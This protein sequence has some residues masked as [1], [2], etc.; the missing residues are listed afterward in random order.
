MIDRWRPALRAACTGPLLCLLAACATSHGGGSGSVPALPAAAPAPVTLEHPP[1]LIVEA[2]VT[3]RQG[4]PAH[5]LKVTDFEVTVDG[6]RRAGLA[7]GRLYRGPGADFSASRGPGGPGEVQPLSESSRIVVMVV[8][9]AS[10]SPGDERAARAAVETLVGMLGL[11]DRLAVVTLPPP[12]DAMTIDFERAAGAKLLANLRPLWG[13]APLP[14]EADVLQA[15][16]PA[17]QPSDSSRPPD[18]EAPPTG[19]GEVRTEASAPG[20]RQRVQAPGAEEIPPDVLKAHAAS[21]LGSLMGIAH[22][23]ESAPGAKTVVLF[24]AGLVA[25]DFARELGALVDEAARAHTRIVSVQVPT[26]S[27]LRGAGAADLGALANATGG[28]L[29]ALGGKPQQALE[30]LAGELSFSYL[31]MLSPMAGDTDPTPRRVAIALKQPGGRTVQ[32]P[33]V[34]LPGRFPPEVLASALSPRAEV[35]AARAAASPPP[36]LAAGTETPG[37]ASAP[38]PGFALFR[39]DP[40]VDLVLARVSQYVWGYIRELSSVVSEETYAQRVGR[41]P[42]SLPGQAGPDAQKRTLAS[43]YLLVMVPGLNG[44]IPFRDVFEVD[45]KPVRDR[46]DRLVKLFVDAP[47]PAVA[48]ERAMQVLRE[49][50]RY[51]IGPVQRT[52][53]VPT[54]PIS[55]LEPASTHR[56]AFRKADETKIDGRTAWVLEFTELV[57]PTF[58]RTNAGADLPVQGR[59]WVDPLNGRIFQTRIQASTATITVK[60]GLHPEISGLWLPQTMQERYVV[61]NTEIT[62]TA[63]YSK[64]RRFTVLT[65]ELVTL[66][67]K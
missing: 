20:D 33:R 49:S 26:A 59:V 23:L 27:A 29:L 37:P 48:I 21:T 6:R 55:F 4:A 1:G 11:S 61:G 2:I 62:G 63:T 60:Y 56:F 42:G 57:R 15:P 13:R 8:D 53:N 45:G 44:W 19:A 67:K 31:L 66:P 54:L 9:Q 17:A 43:D 24:S 38:G 22:A 32:A 30:R 16:R 51:N 47:S 39:H 28:R 50:A 18:P 25:A 58:V 65:N 46:E 64:Y 36:A 10:F 35:E 5:D 12:A 52:V 34:V 40:S 3:D 7:L 14:A 41:L